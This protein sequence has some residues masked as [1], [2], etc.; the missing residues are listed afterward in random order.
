MYEID[1]G[2]YLIEHTHCHLSEGR[3]RDM[4]KRELDTSVPFIYATTDLERELKHKN[5]F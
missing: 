5:T 1:R 3:W 2:F 4:L